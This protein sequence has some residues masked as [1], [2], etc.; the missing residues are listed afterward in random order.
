MLAVVQAALRLTRAENVS[1]FVQ[2]IN[3]RVAAIA[4]AQTL[5][6]ADS[7][8][9]ADLH[10]ML[11]DE[12]AA[13]LGQSSPGPRATLDGPQLAL[14]AA[15]AQPF[16]MALHELATNAIKFGAL[17]SPTGSLRISW[18]M[19]EADNILR[20][21][22]AENGGPPV[23]G[24]P[25]RRGFGSRVLTTTMRMQMGG[26][27]FMAWKSTGLVCDFAVPLP[28]IRPADQLAP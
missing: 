16:S 10:M 27:I 4:R 6:A 8:S 14:P 2:A 7:W 18:Q 3:G 15:A 25:D 9:G 28:R 13:Y 23:P 11:R 26:T 19:D 21:R 24:P 20:F 17:S 1:S 12:L 22:W 5:L